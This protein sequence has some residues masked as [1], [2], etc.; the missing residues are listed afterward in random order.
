MGVLTE[1]NG[2]K[3]YGNGNAAVLKTALILMS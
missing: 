2:N 1:K 3:N